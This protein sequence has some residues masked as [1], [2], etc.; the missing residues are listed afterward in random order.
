M[1]YRFFL[2]KNIYEKWNCVVCY[3]LIILVQVRQLEPKRVKY[4]MKKFLERIGTSIDVILCVWHCPHIGDTRWRSW[5]R[6]CVT[7][8]KVAG[9]IPD[10]VIG[11]FH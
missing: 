10:G 11:I 1:T 6:Y 3:S 2:L 4:V 7:S 5:L 9:S 8:W